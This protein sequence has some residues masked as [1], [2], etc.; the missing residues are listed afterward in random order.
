MIR[1]EWITGDLDETT[2]HEMT[3][4]HLRN[5]RF[6]LVRRVRKTLWLLTLVILEWLSRKVTLRKVKHD[7][8]IGM[9]EQEICASRD[10]NSVEWLEIL[11]YDPND[12]H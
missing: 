8:N 11:L 7:P 2:F 1:K 6:W 9:I 10:T 3:D 5:L 4:R 12:F